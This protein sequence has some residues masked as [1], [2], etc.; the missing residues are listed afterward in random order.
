MS[1]LFFVWFRHKYNSDWYKYLPCGALSIT[2]CDNKKKKSS[3]WSYNYKSTIASHKLTLTARRQSIINWYHNFFVDFFYFCLLWLWGT[4]KYKCS[5][6]IAWGLSGMM[7]CLIVGATY[8]SRQTVGTLKLQ[9][10]FIWSREWTVSCTDHHLGELMRQKVL[11]TPF[12]GPFPSGWMS[13]L[14]QNP[15]KEFCER[16]TSNWQDVIC[17]QSLGPGT[18][19]AC[20]LPA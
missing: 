10:V 6:C 17:R 18:L 13:N 20:N 3:Y 15:L 8:A 12:F 2:P 7:K 16:I 1:L 4:P 9:K 19:S 14:S 5:N 11:D